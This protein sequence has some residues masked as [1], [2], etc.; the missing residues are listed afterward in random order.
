MPRDL[1]CPICG[2]ISLLSMAQIFTIAIGDVLEIHSGND[3]RPFVGKL[4]VLDR[5]NRQ[6]KVSTTRDTV[7]VERAVTCPDFVTVPVGS[8]PMNA[9]K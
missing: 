3:E 7:L 8:F 1:I 5:G 9:K 2:N 6:F 4:L